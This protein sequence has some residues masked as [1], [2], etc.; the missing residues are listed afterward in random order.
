MV[1]TEEGLLCASMYLSPLQVAGW[2]RH[3]VPSFGVLCCC[4]SNPMPVAR[5][6]PQQS[7][8][9]LQQQLQQ[10]QRL[11]AAVARAVQG[12]HPASSSSSCS[13]SSQV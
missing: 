12:V 9:W 3:D 10:Q 7:P 6:T 1:V 4:V 2:L 11:V 5:C 13:C 8:A